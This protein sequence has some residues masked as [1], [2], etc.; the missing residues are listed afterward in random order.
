MKRNDPPFHEDQS[1][2]RMKMIL[3]VIHDAVLRELLH[4]VIHR[5]T[6]YLIVSA[7]TGSEA[8]TF[9]QDVVPDLMLLDDDL[10]D[11]GVIELYDLLHARKELRHVPTII[12]SDR[13]P[14]MEIQ[15]KQRGL[16]LLEKPFDPVTFVYVIE[17]AM[18]NTNS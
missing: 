8:I 10:P 15:V 14:D 9:S 5:K 4:L 1:R 12:M 17:R 13:R 18:G 6:S 16:I 7:T 3:S 11:Q 2:P